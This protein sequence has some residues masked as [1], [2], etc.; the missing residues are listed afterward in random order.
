MLL[1]HFQKNNCRW[2]LAWVKLVKLNTE[3]ADVTYGLAGYVFITGGA[4]IRD[5]LYL[6]EFW[7]ACKKVKSNRRKRNGCCVLLQGNSV[8]FH[9][10]CITRQLPT[11]ALPLLSQGLTL[12]KQSPRPRVE[13]VVEVLVELGEVLWGKSSLYMD[14]ASSCTSCISYLR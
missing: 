12:L 13:E 6:L 3:S 8:A 14:L 5:Q 10:G 2:V 7:T 1:S 11:A 9:Q 4:F